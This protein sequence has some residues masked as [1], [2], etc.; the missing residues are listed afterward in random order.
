MRQILFLEQFSR[1]SGGQ[2]VLLQII[3]GL[4]RQRWSPRVALPAE[5]ELADELAKRSVPCLIWPVGSYSAGRKNIW[6]ALKYFYF[7]GRLVPQAAAYIKKE[8]ISLVYANAPRTFLWGTFAARLAGRPIVWHL[9]SILAGPE[10]WLCRL[11][12]RLCRIDLLI[13]ISRAVAKP[14]SAATGNRLKVIYNGVDPARFQV[15]AEEAAAWRRMN[16]IPPAAK[17]ITYVGQ[18]AKWK[19]V[20]TLLRAAKKVLSEEP[21]AIFLLAGSRLFGGDEIEAGAGD[22]R[23]RWLG[24][25]NDIPLLLAATDLLVV[26]SLK[27]EP[28]SLALLEGMAAGKAVIATEHGGPGEVITNGCDGLL[29]RPGDQAVL[30][31]A[32]LALLG[33]QQRRLVLGQNARRTAI[34]RFAL[35]GFQAELNRNIDRVVEKGITA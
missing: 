26:P 10:L 4:D 32:I 30:A 13:A 27:P 21:T 33:D 5:G 18:I 17:V 23:I 29:C 35:A 1:I 14:F 8:G 9:H 3:D 7:T 19:G 31:A 16:D 11:F 25:R 2:V 34:E 22:Q 20:E 24:Q 12:D 28:L 6:D 15:E